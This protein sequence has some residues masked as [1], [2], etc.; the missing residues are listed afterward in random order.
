MHCD[1]GRP[2][3][4]FVEFMRGIKLSNGPYAETEP[5]LLGKVHETRLGRVTDLMHKEWKF[6]SPAVQQLWECWQ[7]GHEAGAEDGY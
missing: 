2:D 6:D 3:I 7:H 1:D 5:L 4:R